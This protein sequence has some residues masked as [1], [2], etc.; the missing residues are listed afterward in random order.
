M[1]YDVDSFDYDLVLGLKIQ[2]RHKGNQ[3]TKRKEKYLDAITSFDIETSRLTKYLGLDDE[4]TAMYLWQFAFDDKLVMGR[5]WEEFEYFLQEICARIKDGETLVCYVQNLSYEFQFLRTIYHFQSD[6]VFA[7]KSRKV[8]RA[9]MYSRKIELRCLYLLTNMGLEES[10]KKYNVEHKKLSGEEFDYNTIR[11]PWTKLTKK[12]I[13]YGA[14]DVL[15]AVEVVKAVMN[16][17]DDNLYSIPMTSTGYVRRDAKRAMKLV[18]HSVINSLMPD[19][20]LYQILSEA[21]RGGNTHASRFYAGIVIKNVKSYD[22]SSSYPDCQC[23]DEFPVTKFIEQDND[24]ETVYNLIRKHKAVVFRCKIWNLELND[25]VPCP[26][27]SKSK[28]RNI[29]NAYCDNGRIMAADYL[30]TTLTDIDFNI[31]LNDYSFESI[32]F[33]DVY[34]AR[35]GK[36]PR[37]LIELIINYYKNKTE[38][39]DVEGQE[40]FY[41]KNKNLL[42]SIYGMSAQR[43]VKQSINFYDDERA[44][45]ECCD[46]E[47]ELLIEYNRKAFLPYQWGVWTTAQAR[48][49]L[50]KAIWEAGSRFV[51]CDTDSVKVDGDIDLTEYNKN[52]I[53]QSKE[54]GAYAKDKKGKVHYMGVFEYEGCYDE[55][56][57]LGAKRYAYRNGNEIYITVAG[58]SK[59]DG[60][61][62]IKQNG[63]LST[64]RDGFIFRES[65]KL[66]SVYDDTRTRGKILV[67]NHYLTIGKNVTLRPTTYTLGLSDEYRAVLENL[68]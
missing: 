42:N 15:G 54:S 36:L 62:E 13:Q 39:K 2:K 29:V 49:E 53:K 51:Y 1:I 44:F 43:P 50:Q 30:E 27:I 32:E 41:M 57:T 18:S 40:I 64:F 9:Y 48:W 14:H 35:Y 4:L 55:F 65:G 60:A 34:A 10:T 24:S 11:L 21:F 28:C 25:G 12:Q 67:D 56:I 52:K 46:N 8:L 31:L 61:E 38:L 7:I 58:V 3:G 22:R 6:E 17:F 66:E 37:P 5:T 20:E 19:F 33:F 63:G 68:R 16:L 59:K 45:E 47:E 23:N 26:Y